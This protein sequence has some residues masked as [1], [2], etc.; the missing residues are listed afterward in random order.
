MIRKESFL[1]Q[2]VGGEHLLVP[3]GS[4]VMDTNGIITL[5]ETAAFIWGQL[6]MERTEDELAAALVE[7]FNVDKETAAADV[8]S[9][10]LTMQQNGLLA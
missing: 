2:T 9:F 4:Q 3:L 5:N 1:L 6:K 8:S 10:V 7:K